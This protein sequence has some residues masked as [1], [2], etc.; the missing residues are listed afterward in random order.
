MK[1]N[2]KYLIVNEE[3][4][5]WGLTVNTVGHQNVPINSAYPIDKH[6]LQ[7]MSPK[8][9][10]ILHEYQLLYIP[11]GKGSFESTSYAKTEISE[12]TMFL[13][14][15]GEWHTYCPQKATGWDEYWI[16]FEGINI[17]NRV[18][19]GFFNKENPIFKVGINEEIVTLYQKAI[20]T[21][22]Q[23]KAGYQIVLA[24]IVNHLLGLAFALNKNHVLEYSEGAEMI[25][26]AKIFIQENIY[27]PIS[28]EEVCERISMGYS[29]FRKAFKTQTGYSP[30]QYILEVKLTQ[31]KHLLTN[32]GKSVKEIAFEL[33]FENAEYFSTIF[34]RKTNMTPLEYRGKSQM[35]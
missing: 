28:P 11:N 8:A 16:G 34:K 3:D 33:A 18:N 19:S 24:G 7:Y 17:D 23:Q 1:E 20:E 26:K 6:P 30:A 2:L 10:R 15:P 21:A 5:K 13:L 29:S 31:A 27:H 12:G 32:S 9:G 22:S 14:F 4:I 25:Q 35:K